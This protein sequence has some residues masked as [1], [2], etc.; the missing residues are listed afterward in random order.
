MIDDLTWQ[1]SPSL[2]VAEVAVLTPQNIESELSYAY[3]HAIASR[4]GIICEYSGRHSDEAGVD[5][6]LRVK[7]RLAPDSIFTQFTVDVKLKATK[8][9]PIEQ[10]GRYSHSLKVKNYNE[11]RS[12]NTSAP[13]LLVVLFLPEDAENWLSHSEDGLVTRRCAY[14]VSVRGA[15]ETDQDSRTIY[16]PRANLLS[17]T[18]LRTLMTRFSRQEVLNYAP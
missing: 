3:L 14:W 9:V 4:A 18:G 1:E 10:N 2:R 13:Q 17:V 11:L 8:K 5:A 16:V 7:G 6:V 12:T 15:V